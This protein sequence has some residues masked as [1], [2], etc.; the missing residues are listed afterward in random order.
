MLVDVTGP[1]ES[2]E[3]ALHVRMLVYPHPEEARTFF[4]RTPSR[5]W[6]PMCRFWT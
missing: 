2:V 5:P 1:V 3:K 4:A 6:P